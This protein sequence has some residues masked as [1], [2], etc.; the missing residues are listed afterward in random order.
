MAGFPGL[1]FVDRM[2]IFGDF[3]RFKG[4]SLGSES[5]L[6]ELPRVNHLYS[7]FAI[8]FESQRAIQVTHFL[9]GLNHP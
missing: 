2:L 8:I 1:T 7:R 9:N 5:K 3:E 4:V 6:S